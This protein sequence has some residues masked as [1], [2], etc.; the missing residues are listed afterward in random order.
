MGTH[1]ARDVLI[2]MF[3]RKD[4]RRS[5]AESVH[6]NLFL[7]SNNILLLSY[8]QALDPSHQEEWQ[9]MCYQHY[10]LYVVVL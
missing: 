6:P 5:M 2:A 8:T 9:M 10:Y 3:V 1:G 4:S 7:L